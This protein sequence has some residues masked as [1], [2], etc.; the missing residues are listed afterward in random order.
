MSEYKESER[1]I[2]RF[3][4]KF[5]LLKKLVKRFYQYLN[6][7]IYRKK[8]KFQAIST[9]R[10]LSVPQGETFFGYY[11]KSPSSIDKRYILYHLTSLS[12]RKKPNPNV[13]IN[14]CVWDT[15]SE[16]DVYMGETF[17]YNWQQGSRAQWL[18]ASEFIY[19][20]YSSELGYH[21]VKVEL[22]E[23]GVKE[24]SIRFPIYDCFQ[25]KY[26]LS[27]SFE[28][29]HQLRPDYGYRN[30]DIT[31]PLP[32]Y[33]EDGIFFINLE[34]G[35]INLLISLQEVISIDMAKNETESKHKFNHIMI[36]PDGNSFM[37]L[38]RYYIGGRR[39]DRLIVAD[40]NGS[41]VRVLADDEMVSHCFWY[42]DKHIIGYK[43]DYKLGDRYYKIEINSKQK[44]IIGKGILDKYGDGHPFVHGDFM[45]FD[46]YPNKARMKELFT[47]DI[48]KNKLNKLGEFYEGMSYYGETRCDLHPRCSEDGKT[49]YFDSVHTGKRNLY[50]LD[51]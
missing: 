30:H 1:K 43:R 46:T 37:F 16:R 6:F 36:S 27:V 31:Q 24:S 17:A 23:E 39:F 49:V 11:D 19:N 8:Y 50:W 44:T 21:S 2:A 45:T 20:N 7:W 4:S 35:N 42:D 14:V 38:H 9:L 32:S 5:P 41:N 29:L 25:N 15:F 3:F 47:F 40:I 51:V 22:N 26:A 33:S 18:A 12:T 34:N 28:R 13:P 48:S 10:S